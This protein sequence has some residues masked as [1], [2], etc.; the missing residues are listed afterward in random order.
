MGDL[1]TNQLTVLHESFGQL[2]ELQELVLSANQLTALPESFGQLLALQELDL[3]TKELTVLPV[4]FG[5]LLA[6]QNFRL[7]TIQWLRLTIRGVSRSC[8]RAVVACC[9]RRSRS[10][11]AGAPDAH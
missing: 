8:M 1:S 10:L 6:L 9:P 4:S 5:Q 3:W 2:L 7:E 11:G